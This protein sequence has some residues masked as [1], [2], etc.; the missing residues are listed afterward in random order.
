MSD[1]EF[2]E[3]V[4]VD[5]EEMAELFNYVLE[6]EKALRIIRVEAEAYFD[7]YESRFDVLME[8]CGGSRP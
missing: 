6:L 5:A 2:G 4:V 3:A 8:G 7:L 1:P